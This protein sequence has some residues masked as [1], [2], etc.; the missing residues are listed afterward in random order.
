MYL[1][2]S[3]IHDLSSVRVSSL[4][5]RPL[6]RFRKF[7]PVRWKRLTKLA[8]HSQRD[9]R[10]PVLNNQNRLL[11]RAFMRC[12]AARDNRIAILLDGHLSLHSVEKGFVTGSQ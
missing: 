9:I 8:I 7:G 1:M 11:D 5:H 12:A 3:W 4:L 6:Q 10:R 2:E